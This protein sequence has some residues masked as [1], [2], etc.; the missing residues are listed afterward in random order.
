VTGILSLVLLVTGAFGV[1]LGRYSAHRKLR[2]EYCIVMVAVGN[3]FQKLWVPAIPLFV[4]ALI[5]LRTSQA[6]EQQ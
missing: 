2:L 1:L 5:S 4:M 6:E 3:M